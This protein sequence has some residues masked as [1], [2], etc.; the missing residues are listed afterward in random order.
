MADKGSRLVEN[1]IHGTPYYPFTN[2]PDGRMVTEQYRTRHA[3]EKY[4][5]RSLSLQ[6]DT[7]KALTG[8]HGGQTM[9]S[10]EEFQRTESEK[11]S[12]L[13]AMAEG[14]GKLRNEQVS[15]TNAVKIQNQISMQG[16][17]K[18]HD[19]NQQI[20]NSIKRGTRKIHGPDLPQASIS[21]IASYDQ[22]FFD[23]LCAYTKG[24]LSSESNSELEGYIDCKFG[25]GSDRKKVEGFLIKSLK[26]ERPFVKDINSEIRSIMNATDI[27]EFP[28]LLIR[29]DWTTS[30]KKIQKLS[31]CVKKYPFPILQSALQCSYDLISLVQQSHNTP[32]SRDALV[33]FTNNGLVPDSVQHYAKEHYREARKEGTLRD[34]NYN[35]M[36]ANDQRDTANYHLG[37]IV[38]NL[39]DTNNHLINLE[40]LVENFSSV[41][42]CGFEDIA[43][44]LNNGFSAV[45]NGL[46]NI[47]LEIAL[48]RAEIVSE[49]RYIERTV[50]N[51][52]IG[53]QKRVDYGNNLLEELIWLGRNSFANEAM[54]YF[55]DGQSC[56]QV[57]ESLSDV[58]DAYA[59][60]CNGA[61]K[62]RSSA[63][64]QYGAGLASEALDNLK[65]AKERY[66]K[67]AR[68]AHMN[69]QNRLESWAYENIARIEKK[70]W[71]FD[72]AIKF[73]HKAVKADP[74]NLSVHYRLAC[75]LALAGYGE[76]ATESLAELIQK[77]EYFLLRL[78]DE[79]AFEVLLIDDVHDL[80]VKLWDMQTVNSPILLYKLLIEF[81]KFDNDSYALE[82]FRHLV[83]FKPEELLNRQIWRHTFFHKIKDSAKSFLSK[84]LKEESIIYPPQSRYCLTF[85]LY[86]LGF[87]SSELLKVFIAE[88]ET[89]PVYWESDKGQAKEKIAVDLQKVGGNFAENLFQNIKPIAPE[90]IRHWLFCEV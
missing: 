32:L 49:L 52:G 20:D 8:P 58:E 10:R 45:T 15:T 9:V 53:I 88:L 3:L 7:L 48:S 18:L 31:Q 81:L 83:G 16:F 14:I 68:H 17:N 50:T 30:Q 33:R 28:S 1:L 62:L 34:I 85:L 44:T 22:G 19:D 73:A 56:L 24:M 60:F 41:V 61:E 59:S 63:E 86:H 6:R 25:S 37:S 47:A 77:D 74:A 79:P 39:S 72:N 80:Y 43:K 36:E 54:Q 57:A 12:T 38:N 78:A 40:E 64:N 11:I 42:E 67:A 90:A 71:S 35:L 66:G 65:E 2:T 51:V 84:Q 75:Y 76:E 29:A 5:D 69:Q 27:I 13:R 4:Q 55:Q 21:T 26:K 89:D 23:S 87:T 46:D 70:E 82:I